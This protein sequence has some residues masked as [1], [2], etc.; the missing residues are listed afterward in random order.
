MMANENRT[1]VGTVVGRRDVPGVKRLGLLLCTGV[2]L[3]L[4]LGIGSAQTSM[5]VM[6]WRE[7]SA[8]KRT[9]QLGGRMAGL[10]N[11][12]RTGFIV[13]GDG[14]FAQLTSS[15]VHT[16]SPEGK[17]FYEGF[18]MYD[19][20]DGSSI[21][22]K[23]DVSGEHHGKQVGTITFVA[24][25]GRFKSITGRGT[26]SSWLPGEWDMYAEVETSFSIP[27]R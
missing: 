9:S 11:V 15:M 3:V 2:V 13:L 4:S 24:G 5:E 25:T 8:A 27:A 7:F 18:A 19:F 22:A 26:V 21:L 23:V 6:R 20:Q 16:N 10:H 17:A 12:D 14:G 1:H